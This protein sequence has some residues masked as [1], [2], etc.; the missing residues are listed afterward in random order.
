MAD[1]KKLRLRIVTPVKTTLDAPVDMVIMK[2]IDGELGVMRDHEPLATVL[3]KGVL[4]YFD[5]E[6]IGLIALFGGMAE[7]TGDQVVVLADIAE[8]PE[9]I[10]AERAR[11]A[12]ERARRRLTE[13]Q[14]DLD[15]QRAKAALRKALV[16]QE[17]TGKLTTAAEKKEETRN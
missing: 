4:R 1:N 14:A 9:E 15:E 7:I 8:K 12:E 5:D 10:D 17:V 13:K 3:D 6:K 2:A 16:R 11:R